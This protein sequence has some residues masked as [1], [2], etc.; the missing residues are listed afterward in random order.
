MKQVV[1]I[2]HNRTGT[3]TS[4][5]RSDEMQQE[6]DSFAPSSTGSSHGLG[7]IRVMQAK[8]AEAM[9]SLPEGN[10]LDLSEANQL[11]AMVVDKLGE[12]M[13]FEASGTRLYEALVSKHEAFGSFD[14]GP[15][16]EDLIEIL[17]EEHRHY[18]MVV[19]QIRTMGGDPTVVTPGA[20]LVSTLSQ[21]I[22]AVIT[23]PRANFLQSLQAIQLAEMADNEGWSTLTTLAR[24]AG[25]FQLGDACEAAWQT[26]ESHLSKVRGWLGAGHRDAA[27]Q[28]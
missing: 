13:A 20:D 4:S 9:G 28:P 19:D 18:H 22:L 11:T 14:G 26:E 27:A 24:Q 8:Q 25:E 10:G 15:S 3:H 6:M 5:G 21:G 1:T 12:R 23:D 17:N 2:G 7:M 16:R